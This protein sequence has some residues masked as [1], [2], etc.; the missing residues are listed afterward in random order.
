[1]P[2][3]IPSQLFSHAGDVEWIQHH[4]SVEARK[5]LEQGFAGGRY[6]PACSVD[7]A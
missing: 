7:R 4:A 3:N 6:K 5:C 1:M 2:I